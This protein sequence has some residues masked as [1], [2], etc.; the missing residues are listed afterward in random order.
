MLQ[1]IASI[2]TYF[3]LNGCGHA[4][5]NPDDHATEKRPSAYRYYPQLEQFLAAKLHDGK[6]DDVAELCGGAGDTGALPV[7]WVYHK[8]PTST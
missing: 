8:G 5:A 4:A 6:F 2:S 7:R 3:G 1:C